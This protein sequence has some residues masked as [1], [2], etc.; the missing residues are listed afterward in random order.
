MY[1]TAL[2]ATPTNFEVDS[3]SLKLEKPFALPE[4]GVDDDD[5]KKRALESVVTC[6]NSKQKSEFVNR[7]GD[8]DDVDCFVIEPELGARLI[9]NSANGMLENAGLS[10]HRTF[11]YPYIP[12]SAVKGVARHAAWMD[13]NETAAEDKTTKD[14]KALALARIF[15]YPTN[16]RDVDAFLRPWFGDKA[17]AGGV[18]FYPA[19]PAA[20]SVNCEVDILNVHHRD[21]YAG[22]RETATDDENPILC[23][24]PVVKAG[25]KFRFAIRRKRSLSDGDFRLAQKWLKTGLSLLGVGAKTSAG[26]GWFDIPE[27]C[28]DV[29]ADEEMLTRMT[30]SYVVNGKVKAEAFKKAYKKGEIA[31]GDDK[32]KQRAVCEFMDTHNIKIGGRWQEEI[33]GWKKSFGGEV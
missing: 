16:E 11:G 20:G 3:P 26:Y 31:V 28:S 13:W 10:L 14:S 30:S 21:Y 12:G 6:I 23:Y 8:E 25:Q 33:D 24:F 4:K 15:G 19:E 32:P 1:K 7:W 27:D 9:V 5:A 2:A 29:M 22:K 18:C 17:M